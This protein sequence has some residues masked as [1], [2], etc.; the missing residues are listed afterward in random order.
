MPIIALTPEE[1]RD[2][3]CRSSKDWRRA[4][5]EEIVDQRRWVTV[6]SAVFK[7]LPT[8]KHYDFNWEQGSTEMQEQDPYEFDTVVTVHEVKLVEK[9]VKI[10]EIIKEE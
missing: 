4:S 7:H 10:W 8:D 1:A 6:Y 2:I 3:V 9:I 5:D